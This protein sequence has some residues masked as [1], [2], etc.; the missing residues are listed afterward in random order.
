LGLIAGLTVP[1]IV[2]SV[3]KGKNKALLKEAFQT[4]SA[5]TQAGVLNGDFTNITDWNITTSNNPQGIV[6][7]IGSKLSYSKQCLTADVASPGCIRATQGGAPN[8]ANNQHNGR[9]LLS[10]GAKIA[11]S[12]YVN[13]S[14]VLYLLY[15]KPYASDYV[16]TG[17]NPDYLG[18]LCNHTDQTIVVNTI[19]FKSGQCDGDTVSDKASL[20]T[21]LF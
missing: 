19:T 20:A 11:F 18:V 9:W 13:T 16:S 15:A 17:S 6:G 14:F 4:V 21:I 8:D 10:N 2:V 1:S 12:Q 5:I 7:Y 3:D